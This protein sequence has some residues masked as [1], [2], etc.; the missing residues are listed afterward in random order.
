MHE[1]KNA[2]FNPYLE[3]SKSRLLAHSKWI[4][5]ASITVINWSLQQ[6]TKSL[7]H[8]RGF[9]KRF[10]NYMCIPSLAYTHLAWIGP[11]KLLEINHDSLVQ[12]IWI[13]CQS[14]LLSFS[15]EGLKILHF[16]LE[17]DSTRVIFSVHIHTTC[18]MG[19]YGANVKFSLLEFYKESRDCSEF[20]S[21]FETLQIEWK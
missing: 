19:G 13:L 4:Q 12:N 5:T 20:W 11:N 14:V 17:F 2:R 15:P 8:A 16:S 21:K 7:P 3:T 18:T 6:S 1:W 10:P 9:M